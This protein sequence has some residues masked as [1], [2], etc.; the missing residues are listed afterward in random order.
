[1]FRF[2]ADYRENPP[3][4]GDLVE[5]VG[6]DWKTDYLHK[7]KK[8]TYVFPTT[9]TILFRPKTTPENNGV[10]APNNYIN[11]I[12]LDDF[13]ADKP[14]DLFYLRL[15]LP[16]SN[17]VYYLKYPEGQFR[18]VLDSPNANQI[19]PGDDDK[20]YIGHF[21]YEDTPIETP[22][23]EMWGTYDFSSMPALAVWNPGPD[24][25]KIIMKFKVW[26]CI[27][28]DAKDK[29]ISDYYNAGKTPF[30]VFSRGV[31]RW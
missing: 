18:G 6:E 27:V 22:M 2:L 3:T 21:T 14:S 23:L 10:L 8:V 16:K 15:G 20:G 28:D 24:F 17:L 19:K 26:E 13:M 29:E 25:E 4:S 5:F 31:G 12:R 11:V 7:T 30:R 1:M 9:R